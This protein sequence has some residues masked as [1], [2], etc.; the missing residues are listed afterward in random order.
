MPSAASALR[1]S[2]MKGRLWPCLGKLDAS[3]RRGA[4]PGRV[5][6]WWQTGPGQHSEL[7]ARKLTRENRAWGGFRSVEMLQDITVNS[8]SLDCVLRIVS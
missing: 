3:W 7:H 5:G 4:I 2:Q 6:V 1:K 8:R